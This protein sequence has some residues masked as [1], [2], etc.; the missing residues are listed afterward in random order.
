MKT[1]SYRPAPVREVL[2][3]KGNGETRPLGISN[4]EDKLV[5]RI[6]SKILE[7]IY[8]PI[9]YKHSYGY[10]RGRNCHQ[11]VKACLQNLFK[12]KP[13]I[14]IDVDLENFFG[15]IDH[16]KLIAVLR[17]KIKDEIFIG[18]IVRMLKAGV[19]A[20][21]ELK[22]T[23]EGTPQGSMVSPILANIFAHYAIDE[24]F[25]REVKTSVQEQV[26]LYRYCDDMV[27]VW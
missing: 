6:F 11:A 27:I 1:K 22:K 10:R 12:G 15:T 5:Q 17:M 3:P 26:G 19:L 4:L 14:V 13:E 18:Y 23:E 9:F 7:A 2:I 24:W 16:E 8:E 25:V 21:G 20:E